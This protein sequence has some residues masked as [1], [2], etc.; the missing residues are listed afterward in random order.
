MTKLQC[1]RTVRFRQR[2]KAAVEFSLLPSMTA[3][4]FSRTSNSN[5]TL[6]PTSHSLYCGYRRVEG[7]ASQ[8]FIGNN[9]KNTC[10]NTITK[11]GQS[12]SGTAPYNIF[13]R[14]Q[15]SDGTFTNW[16][17]AKDTPANSSS[18]GLTVSSETS[19]TAVE[20]ALSSS[21]SYLSV[22][23]A[24]IIDRVVIPISKDG[25]NGRD[26]IDGIDGID[27]DDGQDAPA[28]F[29]TPGS[30]SIPCDKDGKVI[31]TVYQSLTF[32]MSVGSHAATNVSASVRGSLPSGV[33][34]SNGVLTINVNS[35]AT[36]VDRGASF[37]VTGTYDNDTYSAVCT[38]AIIPALQGQSITGHTGRFYYYAGSYDSRK[39]YSMRQTQAPYVSV[40]V[41]GT[42]RFY[43]LDFKGVEPS[44]FPASATESPTANGQQEWTQMDSEHE[45]FISRAIFG[46]FAHLGA[47]IICGNWMLSQ[48]GTINGT[49]S[50][51]FEEFD[52]S[53]PTGQVSGNFAPYYIVDMLRGI[54]Y[55]QKGA[56][57]G[58]IISKDRISAGNTDYS[59]E[60]LSGSTPCVSLQ[61]RLS[62]LNQVITNVLL[63]AYSAAGSAVGLFSSTDYGGGSGQS[64]SYTSLGVLM[65]DSKDTIWLDESTIEGV[66]NDYI[67]GVTPNANYNI[68]SYVGSDGCLLLAEGK[69]AYRANGQGTRYLY[70]KNAILENSTINT[71]SDERLKDIIR[72]TLLTAEKIANAPAIVY[73][74]KNETDGK[75]FVGSIAQYWHDVLPEVVSEGKDGYLSLNY[76][77]LATVSVIDLAREVVALKRENK[78]L[79]KRLA[80]IEK[81]LAS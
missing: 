13:Y 36:N 57:G 24:N 76:P 73:S 45:Y 8:D 12:G 69:I 54:T 51:D 77:A 74:L 81:N 32:S 4:H 11:T 46:D 60:I 37:T 50:T 1:T 22:S 65:T 62:G 67:F 78:S 18:A 42:R 21:V 63:G 7:D 39:T 3:I 2:G 16:S 31:E 43:M 72:E 25:R 41:N 14:Y 61:K 52:D 26:G 23:D 38:L 44:S 35:L 80:A 47:L 71:G 10:T 53:D 59:L 29:V 5:N 70:I 79:R 40:I 20:Y 34:Y 17:W 64:V 19:Y 27:G 55:Q 9:W 66:I 6:T 30:L 58:W 75:T 68:R 56:V 28:A 15:K 33:S 48:Y 49:E